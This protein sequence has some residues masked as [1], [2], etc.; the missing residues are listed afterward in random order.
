MFTQSTSMSQMTN[1]IF[2][3]TRCVKCSS[4]HD[5][6]MNL[7][8]QEKTLSYY[9]TSIM[10]RNILLQIVHCADKH[11]YVNFITLSTFPQC[12][13]GLEFPELP[14]QNN[15]HVQV[16]CHGPSI[17]GNSKM[18]HCGIPFNAHYLGGIVALP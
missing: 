18:M 3:S 17:N 16:Y 1:S 8:W 2:Q 15:I 12:N 5:L 14:S 13:F 7:I 11:K 4:D 9:N 10:P 6:Q